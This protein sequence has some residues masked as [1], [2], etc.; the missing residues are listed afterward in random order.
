MLVLDGRIKLRDVT[1][2]IHVYPN[3]SRANVKAAGALLQKRYLEG[4][5]GEL[6]RGLGRMMIRF[7]RWRRGF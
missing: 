4:K 1:T 6:I 7:M 5:T 3:Y 2:T